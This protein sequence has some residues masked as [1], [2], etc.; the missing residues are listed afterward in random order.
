MYIINNTFYSIINANKAN[1]FSNA[2]FTISN[3]SIINKL[4]NIRVNIDFDFLNNI[5]QHYCVNHFINMQSLNQEYIDTI[6]FLKNSIK[7][8]DYKMISYYSKRIPVLQKA[9]IF[10][11]I[12]KNKTFDYYIPFLFDFRGRIYKLSSISPTFSKELRYCMN[13]EDDKNLNEKIKETNDIK[14]EFL[15]KKINNIISKR[16]NYIEELI[17]Y[18]NLKNLD[19]KYKI[20]LI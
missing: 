2:S 4:I 10:E 11:K 7:N 14:I 12:I 19:E 17:H 15:E 16:F 18:K 9:L 3:K 1:F 20:G 5:N 13:L 6:N 8:E